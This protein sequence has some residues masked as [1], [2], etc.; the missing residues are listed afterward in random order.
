M[1]PKN[2]APTHK[3][4]A[5]ND[6]LEIQSTEPQS[7]EQPNDVWE[8]TINCLL[9][10]RKLFLD[11]S[12]EDDSIILNY[13]ISHSDV[14]DSGDATPQQVMKNNP[15]EGYLKAIDYMYR[16]EAEENL[17]LL[18]STKIVD[19]CSKTMTTLLMEIY[20]MIKIHILMLQH[21]L[22]ILR[23]LMML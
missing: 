20:K 3:P 10:N 9:N 23:L 7:K 17:E 15:A 1:V 19:V 5:P 18:S 12:I 16:F 2:I 6:D 21:I 8:S 13:V 14:V 22:R 11:D 4:I